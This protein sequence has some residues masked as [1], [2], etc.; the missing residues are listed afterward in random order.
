MEKVSKGVAVKMDVPAI[1]A[2]STPAILLMVPGQPILG[3]VEGT[4]LKFVV[5]A[6]WDVISD[7]ATGMYYLLTGKVWVMSDKLDGTWTRAGALPPALKK[8]PAG[9]L[10]NDVRNG[11]A[12]WNERSTVAVPRVFFSS[13]P[14]ELVVFE[15]EPKYRP[16][17]GTKLVWS[18][19]TDSHVFFDGSDKKFYLVVSGRWFRAANLE[20]PWSY[21]GKDLP[22]DFKAIPPS[23]PSASALSSVPGTTD[24]DDAVMLSQ[25]PTTAIVKRSE[26]EAKAK[27]AYN[28]DAVFKPIEGTK[29]AYAANT[30]SDVLQEGANYYLCQE[31]VWF[32]SDS[33]NGPWKITTAIPADVANIPPGSP[34]YRLAYVQTQD[35]SDPSTVECSYTSGYTGSYIAS[36]DEGDQ[37]VWGTGY[38]Y[39]AYVG[40]AG[41]VPLYQPYWAT[42]GL[43]AAYNWGI[44]TY[45]IGGYAYGPY[46]AAGRAAWYNPATGTYNRAAAIA[47]PYGTRAIAE[48]YNPRTGT[49]YATK[50]GTGPYASWGTTAATRGN[51]WVQAG[52]VTT[53]NGTVVGWRGPDGAGGVKTIPSGTAPAAKAASTSA[54][55]A[56]RGNNIYSG[57]DGNIYQRG[58]DGNWAKYGDNGWQAVDRGMAQTE[59]AAARTTET[60][61]TADAARAAADG[62]PNDVARDNAARVDGAAR[63]QSFAQNNGG[64]TDRSG[65]PVA[66]TAASHPAAA[67]QAA[68]NRGRGDPFGSGSFSGA[69]AAAVA[70]PA[71]VSRGGGG[72][73]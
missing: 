31:A 32:I 50:Q 45:G 27:V 6:N 41:G 37:L 68:R 19:N 9:G 49:A 8:L 18:T 26:A 15:G 42:Y 39:P 14:A 38:D 12:G 13:V 28:G 29:L 54:A 2:S 36:T 16:I 57:K 63:A 53:A 43:A 35:T 40:W 1:F 56:D 17:A 25:I 72:R 59:T 47:G 10:W 58:A 34:A 73:R 22:A 7:P 46:G 55:M 23:D 62:I 69:R 4:S 52:H 5:N 20:G 66:T 64:W 44:G 3:P 30:S 48:G 24:A 70:R 51:Q 21:A 71:A 11:A 67:G 65:R 61:R 33:P 60:T